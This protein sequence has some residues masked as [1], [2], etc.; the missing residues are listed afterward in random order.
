M[1]RAIFRF[2]ENIVRFEDPE[3]NRN[4]KQR[5]DLPEKAIIMGIDEYIKQEGIEIG[6][7]RG[8]AVGMEKGRE[9]G[10]QEACHATV[11][12]LLSQTEFDDEK[13]AEFA[14]VKVE[15]VAEMRARMTSPH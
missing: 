14:G 5:T 12:K 1:R 13:I 7:E 6:L 9:E 11:E 10:R 4:F 3:M 8:L 2:L 15:L